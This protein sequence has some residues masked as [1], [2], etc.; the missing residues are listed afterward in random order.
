MQSDFAIDMGTSNT[1]IFTVG[2]GIAVNEP[3]AAVF[4]NTEEE[5][6]EVGTKA[7][8]MLALYYFLIDMDYKLL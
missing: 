6:K 1:R 2:K 4:D 8:E 3:S 7:Y 5:I